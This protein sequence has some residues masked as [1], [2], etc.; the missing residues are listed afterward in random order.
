MTGVAFLTIYVGSA[1]DRLTRNGLRGCVC[2]GHRPIIQPPY[3]PIAALAHRPSRFSASTP[4]D[5]VHRRDD[6]F[7]NGQRM[8]LDPRQATGRPNPHEEPD[9]SGENA[10]KSVRQTWIKRDF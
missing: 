3:G 9:A 4:Y 8:H 2:P 5:Q 10:K 1:P 7:L 6:L